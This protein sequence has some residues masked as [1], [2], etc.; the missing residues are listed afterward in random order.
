MEVSIQWDTKNQTMTA[1]VSP[2]M[3]AKKYNFNP[4]K[5]NFDYA[6]PSMRSCLGVRNHITSDHRLGY[7]FACR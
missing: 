6:F 5:L 1:I 7:A 2:A 4:D 3:V